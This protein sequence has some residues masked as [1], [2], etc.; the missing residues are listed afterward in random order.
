MRWNIA[1]HTRIR[2][3]QPR[4]TDIPVRFIDRVFRQWTLPSINAFLSQLVLVLQLVSEAH[5]CH[6]GTDGDDSEAA[7][8]RA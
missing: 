3:D 5:P 2:V 6:G 4:A 8:G 1:R 7:R